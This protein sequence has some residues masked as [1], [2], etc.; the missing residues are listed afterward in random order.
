MF[1]QVHLSYFQMIK[2]ESILHVADGY[3]SRKKLLVLQMT[4]GYLAN[5]TLVVEWTLK[6]LLIDERTRNQKYRQ[7]LR[8][9]D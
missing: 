9:H 7:P 8:S 3:Y 1:H 5:F 2:L 6:I 4:S